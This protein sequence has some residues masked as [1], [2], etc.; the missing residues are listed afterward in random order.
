MS[1]GANCSDVDRV[2]SNTGPISDEVLEQVGEHLETCKR[3][4]A[5]LELGELIQI[6]DDELRELL[7]NVEQ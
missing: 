7:K 3:C 2:L 1:Q 5:V 6:P 4:R